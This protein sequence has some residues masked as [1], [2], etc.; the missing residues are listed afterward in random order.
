[1][2]TIKRIDKLLFNF[3]WNHKSHKIAKQVVIRGKT[4]GG[5]AMTDISKKIKALK[6]T[7]IKRLLNDEGWIAHINHYSKVD[8][9]FLL[10]CN[11]NSHDINEI[12]KKRDFSILD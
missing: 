2:Q 8:I 7:W 1:M 4:D 11:L 3:L 10:T 9:A 6:V 12:W 5:I